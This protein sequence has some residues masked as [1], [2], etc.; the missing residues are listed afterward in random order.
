M[1]VKFGAM[2]VAGSLLTAGSSF[3]ASSLNSGLPGENAG[4]IC[5]AAAATA[6]TQG[7]ATDSQLAACTLAIKLDSGGAGESE[8]LVRIRS[9]SAVVLPSEVWDRVAAAY[10]N[11]GA[12]HFARS[13]FDK[14]IAD[15]NI[16][17]ELDNHLPEAMINRGDAFLQQH[18]PADA[19]ADFTNAL[20]FAPAHIERVYFDRAMARE[21]MGDIKGAYADYRQ[22]SQLNP[23]WDQPKQELA[24]FKVVPAKPIS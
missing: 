21:D 13:E 2:I 17:L 15:S 16:A 11:R 9:S 14:T 24:R 10:V 6:Q 12:L 8:L 22:A 7:S 23:Q 20:Q 19:A 1:S 18:R 3:A 5:A 4:E